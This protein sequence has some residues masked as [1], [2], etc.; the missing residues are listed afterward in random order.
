MKRRA[1][2]SWISNFACSTK[3]VD[4]II[5]LSVDEQFDLAMK[6]VDPGALRPNLTGDTC[7]LAALV[8]RRGQ[9]EHKFAGACQA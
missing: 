1:P 6:R 4:R 2:N 7:G 3:R 8:N 9:V 5:F